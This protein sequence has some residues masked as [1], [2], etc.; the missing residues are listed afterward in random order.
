[1]GVL[2]GGAGGGEKHRSTVDS[3]STSWDCDDEEAGEEL[4][5]VARIGQEY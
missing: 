3:W 4:H 1:M 2:S 5:L